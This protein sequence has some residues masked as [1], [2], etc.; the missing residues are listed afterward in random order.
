MRLVDVG[1]LALIYLP[2]G[3]CVVW[4]VRDALLKRPLRGR[5]KGQQ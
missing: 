2:I 5:A 4:A 3:L 1:A